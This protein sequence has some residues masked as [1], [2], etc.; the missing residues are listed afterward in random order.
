M[1]GI[2]HSANT[3]DYIT[4][5][6][7]SDSGGIVRFGGRDGGFDVG[8]CDSTTALTVGTDH[9]AAA[10][11]TTTASAVWLDGG[12]KGTGV[13]SYDWPTM[14]QYALGA[15]PRSTVIIPFD[16]SLSEATLL[17][18]EASD[19]DILRHANGESP[20]S[21]WP[22]ADIAYHQSMISDTRTVWDKGTQASGT[23]SG[24]ISHPRVIYPVGPS[25]A[26]PPVAAPEI[27]I[28]GNSLSIANG[29]AASV[30]K[31][32]DYGDVVV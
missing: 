7:H 30:A 3:T 31:G 25:Y 12:S 15:L 23:D 14:N 32:T 21:I 26:F 22:F 2:G 10:T 20:F 19:A 1:F 28:Q 6:V 24:K 17:T 9:T 8:G 29:E 18:I 13:N 16:G 4:L 11:L 27:D 5:G